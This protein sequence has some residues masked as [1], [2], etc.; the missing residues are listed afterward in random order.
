MAPNIFFLP[1]IRWHDISNIIA[2]AVMHDSMIV[3]SPFDQTW[4]CHNV[5]TCLEFRL[6]IAIVFLCST[7]SLNTFTEWLNAVAHARHG[8]P[9]SSSCRNCAKQG[10]ILSYLYTVLATA[11][12]F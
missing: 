12:L 5:C 1:I 10:V 11:L 3:L 9:A 8:W 7:D 2:L 4:T 6:H